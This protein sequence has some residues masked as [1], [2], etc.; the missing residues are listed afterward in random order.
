VNPKVVLLV[1]DEQLFL[2][3]LEDALTH[4]GY[5]VLKART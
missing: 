2:E 1:D 5:H 4:E 3:A